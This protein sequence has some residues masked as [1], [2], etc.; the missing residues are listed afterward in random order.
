[1]HPKQQHG[2]NRLPW[3]VLMAIVIA[4]GL[5]TRLPALP[6]PPSFSGYLGDTLWA[7]AV[8]VGCCLLFPSLSTMKIATLAAM[9]SLLVE[10]SQLYHAPW[11]D[12]TRS[13]TLGHLVLGS[14]FDSIDLVCYAAGTG[15]GV[16]FEMGLIQFAATRA[17]R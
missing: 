17:A 7:L 16:L 8:Y 2:R 15:V 5:G 9:T 6:F 12:S 1:L 3:I 13:T 14:G 4:L 11:I 10:F